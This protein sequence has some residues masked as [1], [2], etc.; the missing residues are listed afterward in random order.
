M[1]PPGFYHDTR[2]DHYR[3]EQLLTYLDIS[4]W[5][6]SIKLLQR[7]LEHERSSTA[8]HHLLRAFHLA[9]ANGHEHAA[10]LFLERGIDPNERSMNDFNSSS[11]SVAMVEGPEVAHRMGNNALEL[12]TKNR[13]VGIVKLLLESGADPHLRYVKKN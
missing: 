5:C 3:D 6:G 2:R 12:A 13:H 8:N 11:S 9:V 10:K 4:A 7:L 1:L